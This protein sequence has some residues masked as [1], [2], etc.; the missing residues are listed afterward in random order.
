MRPA[1]GAAPPEKGQLRDDDCLKAPPIRAL[2]IAGEN[3][4]ILMAYSKVNLLR[5]ALCSDFID[6]LFAFDIL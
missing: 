6:R 4:S 1:R 5:N 2:C 3:C